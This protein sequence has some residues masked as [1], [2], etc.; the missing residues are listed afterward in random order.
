MHQE[1]TY[2][3][4]VSGTALRN[5]D[6]AALARSCGGFGITVTKTEQFADAFA[7]AKAAQTAAVIELQLDNEVLSTGQT[8]SQTRAQGEAARK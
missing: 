4:R 8:L 7:Q 2:P 6:F 1:K 3:G 5:P